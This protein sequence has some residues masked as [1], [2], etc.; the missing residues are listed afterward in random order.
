MTDRH[1]STAGSVHARRWWTL[2]V[3]CF[4]LVVI[5]L[6]NTIL[7]V[8]IPTLQRELH[9]S[10]SQLQWMVDSY[11]LVFAGLLLTAGSLGDRFGR[12]G[13]LQ[14]GLLV[15]GVGSVVAALVDTPNKLIAARALMGVG[16]AFIMP[17]T[18]S[19]LTNVFTDPGE[20]ARAIG[21]WAGVAGIG[22]ALGPLAGGFL[23]E[24]FYWGSIF[25]VNIPVVVI[26]V[27][28]GV[29][30]V[31]TSKDPA[32]PRLDPLGA[33]LS[34]AGLSALLYG[35]IE[36]PG[37]GWTDQLILISFGLAA[38]LLLLFVTW[39]LRTR[40]PMLDVKFFRNP[41][42]SAASTG[43]ALVF[44]SLFGSLFLLTQYFQFVLGYTALQTGV[45]L[46]PYAA[47]L[48]VVAPLSARFVEHIGTKLVVTLGLTLVAAGLF[49]MAQIGVGTSY[50]D[51]VWRIVLVAGGMGC[52]MAPATE[53]IMGSLPLSKAGVGSAV[54]D[55]TR[56]VG[57][58]LGIAIIGSVLASTY[59][60]KIGAAIAKQSRPVPKSIADAM[61][62]QLGAAL[63][64]A[65]RIGG[66]IGALIRNTA[67]HAFVT[68]MH[69]GMVVGGAAALVGAVVAL[70]WL[71]AHA[72]DA[73]EID[74]IVA[75]DATVSAEAAHAATQ[76]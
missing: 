20:R 5:T 6:D 16:G 56:Q 46:L 60:S 59:G 14:L 28:A 63:A 38:V 3:L 31:P 55:T 15:F 54:N 36:A 32:A 2:G 23:V 68:G 21:M 62:S 39:E 1:T 50:G 49:T 27:V 4:S 66:P 48:M 12:R 64:V 75:L 22:I 17:S 13:A 51:I 53:S 37:K 26:A 58:A 43:I 41:R 25:L 8:A 73:V 10:N 29:F 45:R 30:L 74:E 33:V 40:E 47:V 7:N 34:M 70:V 69:Q 72:A 42:F 76:D 11:T 61:K 65:Q 52:T 9:A 67:R 35:I 19:V 44:L 57:G 18:L 24:H 71:P